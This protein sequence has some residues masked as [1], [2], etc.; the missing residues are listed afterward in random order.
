MSQLLPGA[1]PGQCSSY[2]KGSLRVVL[3]LGHQLYLLISISFQIIKQFW[4]KSSTLTIN[5]I[6]MCDKSTVQEYKISREKY[7]W[8]Q[9]LYRLKQTNSGFILDLV[10]FKW[11]KLNKIKENTTNFQK[12]ETKRKE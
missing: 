11:C 8:Q 12:F 3:D 7:I 6:N 10:T 4:P 5:S 9:Q 1:L 2:W